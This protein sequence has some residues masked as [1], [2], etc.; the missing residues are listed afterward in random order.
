MEEK[1]Q[2]KHTFDNFGIEFVTGTGEIFDAFVLMGATTL[3]AVN[4]LEENTIKKTL[5]NGLSFEV[6]LRVCWVLYSKML[7]TLFNVR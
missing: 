2:V 1:Q 5:V 4:S 6:Y 7:I 3:G